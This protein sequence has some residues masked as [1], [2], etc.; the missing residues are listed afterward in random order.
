MKVSTASQRSTNSMA[1]TDPR[2][3]KYRA[4]LAE[5]NRAISRRTIEAGNSAENE[6]QTATYW[7]AASRANVRT[8]CETGFNGGHSA[9]LWLSAN[10]NA[11]VHMFDLFAYA[12][13]RAGEAV[14]R[15]HFGS[16]LVVH[17]GPSSHTL[18]MWRLET[19]RHCDI[20][21]VDGGHSYRD[22]LTDLFAAYFLTTKH[23]TCFIDDTNCR[24]EWC[25]DSAL[26]EIGRLVPVHV[27]ARYSYMNGSRGLT[28]FSFPGVSKRYLPKD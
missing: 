20:F 4:V 16:R 28:L 22:A 14:L 1:P 26:E 18:R 27:Q 17:R 7:A 25:V 5:L 2:V 23:S 9:L 24:S 15:A 19:R 8:I 10:A 6:H 11:T 12:A 13:S 21:S 3:K